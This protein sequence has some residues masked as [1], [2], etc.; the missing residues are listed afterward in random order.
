M[1]PDSGMSNIHGSVKLRLYKSD[2]TA[3]LTAQLENLSATEKVSLGN[4]TGHEDV[5]HRAVSSAKC[6]RSGGFFN[7][8]DFHIHF[9]F[10]T[11]FGCIHFHIFKKIQ[12]D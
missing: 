5:I 12:G 6:E 4:G 10:R 8:F 7:D 2:D 1:V 11:A 3:D 9:V